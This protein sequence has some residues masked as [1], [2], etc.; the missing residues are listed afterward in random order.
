M[1]AMIWGRVEGD[2]VNI[3]FRQ[4]NIF[5]PA[6][7]REPFF[8]QRIFPCSKVNCR[9]ALQSMLW[10]NYSRA[11][12]VRKASGTLNN[13]SGRFS[14]AESKEGNPIEATKET[15]SGRGQGRIRKRY[16]NMNLAVNDDFWI[17]ERLVSS[18]NTFTTL[19]FCFVFW[20]VL[21]WF[22]DLVTQDA[23]CCLL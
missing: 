17:R 9:N 3:F 8:V 16:M 15:I 5:L 22:I 18:F 11:M 2:T 19:L 21:V 23:M 12:L 13:L 1:A 10:K 20:V 6:E 14:I 7:M 4:Q